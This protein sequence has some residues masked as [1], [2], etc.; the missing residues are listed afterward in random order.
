MMELHELYFTNANSRD[1]YFSV[2]HIPQAH[3][4][5]RGKGIKIGII[6]WL[7]AQMTTHL[8]MRNVLISRVKG[9]IYT[10]TKGMA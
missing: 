10:I 6:D 5:G 1:T 3:Q 9:S 8:S 4:A 7:L 2:H